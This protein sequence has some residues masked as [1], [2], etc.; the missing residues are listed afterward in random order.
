MSLEFLFEHSFLGLERDWLATNSSG[1]TGFFSTAGF[2]PIPRSLI[3]EPR[4]NETFERVESLPVVSGFEIIHPSESNLQDWVSV[5]KRGIFAFD[6]DN[7]MKFF[8]LIA[9]PT[10]PVLVDLLVDQSLSEI[11]R[12]VIL[13][14]DSRTQELLVESNP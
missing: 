9:R 2:G 14:W 8:R 1:E 11:A 10:E 7:S 5:A 6:W 3:R 13:N 12:M 4:L